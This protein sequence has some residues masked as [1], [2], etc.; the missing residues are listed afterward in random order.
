MAIETRMDGSVLIIVNSDPATR[1]A[2]N[3]D[4]YEGMEKAIRQASDDDATAEEAVDGR[5]TCN[6]SALRRVLIRDHRKS[7]I[8]S[9]EPRRCPNPRPGR[10]RC[11]EPVSRSWPRSLVAISTVSASSTRSSVEPTAS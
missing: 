5:S 10:S 8:H 3:V 9:Q 7:M 11:R 4:F 2:I 6:P 1:N